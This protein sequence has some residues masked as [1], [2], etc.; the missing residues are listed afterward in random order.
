MDGHRGAFGSAK[1]DSQDLV[2][3]LGAS[4]HFNQIYSVRVE[5]LKLDELG[6][7]D[8]SGLEDLNVFGLGVVVRF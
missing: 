8:R 6:Q 5:Y 1:G 7:D 4:F 2:L 3:G